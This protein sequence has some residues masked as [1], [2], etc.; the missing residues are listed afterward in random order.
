VGK[1]EN[2][3]RLETGKANALELGR[4]NRKTAPV[5]GN[6]LTFPSVVVAGWRVGGRKVDER[7]PQV[8]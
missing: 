3:E 8:L 6:K 2:Q 7:H 1:L 4:M 5:L